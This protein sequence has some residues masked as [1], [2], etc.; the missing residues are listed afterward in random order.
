MHFHFWP[1]I[2]NPIYFTS[3]QKKVRI[4]H[5]FN[6]NASVYS[7]VSFRCCV[8]SILKPRNK[9]C[10]SFNMD[11]TWGHFCSIERED[12]KRNVSRI[13]FSLWLYECCRNKAVL[14]HQFVG[15]L[16]ESSPLWE[17]LSW[18]KRVF[19]LLQHENLCRVY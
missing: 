1:H 9:K 15:D 10:T 13:E 12:S 11:S 2:N 17:S 5:N 3:L 18:F 19:E 8:F 4:R 7:E 14:L 6:K 16:A